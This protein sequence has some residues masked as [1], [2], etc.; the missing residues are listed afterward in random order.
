MV[1]FGGKRLKF[2]W[3]ES[4]GPPKVRRASPG[5]ASIAHSPSWRRPAN[6][7]IHIN[8]FRKADNF[9]KPQVPTPQAPI[10]NRQTRK[11]A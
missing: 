11:V 8:L 4:R 2:A 6:K 1:E 7:P 9:Q 10:R 5:S 3:L